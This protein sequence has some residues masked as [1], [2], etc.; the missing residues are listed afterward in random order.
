[1][2]EPKNAFDVFNQ[3]DDE[4]FHAM[5]FLFLANQ[6]K[7]FLK[8]EPFDFVINQV[9]YDGFKQDLFLNNNDDHYQIIVGNAARGVATT[10]SFV[11]RAEYVWSKQHS[12]ASL[13]YI[14]KSRLFYVMNLNCDEPDPATTKFLLDQLPL[15]IGVKQRQFLEIPQGETMQVFHASNH[16]DKIIC[17]SSSKRLA[18]RKSK[19]HQDQWRLAV[20]EA[21]LFGDQAKFSCVSESKQVFRYQQ[22]GRVIATK[23][24]R[25]YK[26]FIHTDEM[27]DIKNARYSAS[28]VEAQIE[29]ERRILQ[30]VPYLKSSN[31]FFF[32]DDKSD[33]IYAHFEKKLPGKTLYYWVKTRFYLPDEADESRMREI[34]DDEARAIHKIENDNNLL[35]QSSMIS[36]CNLL[37]LTIAQRIQLALALVEALMRVHAAGIIHLDLKPENVVTVFNGFFKAWFVDFNIS[38]LSEEV[39]PNNSIV[40]SLLYMSPEAIKR[41]LPGFYSD[42]FSLGIMLAECFGATFAHLDTE[43]DVFEALAKPYCFENLF[44]DVDELTPSLEVCITDILYGMVEFNPEK[45]LSLSE[46]RAAF[47]K[48][49]ALAQGGFVESPPGLVAPLSVFSSEQSQPESSVVSTKGM[50]HV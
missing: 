28:R 44:L 50:N 26:R 46:V 16:L 23:K 48:T 3:S 33:R 12:V 4:H 11:V 7:R 32:I 17:V 36:S 41:T 19:K 43:Q 20:I 42:V 2:F 5:L 39:T 35:L 24:P 38:R 27:R 10:N 34:T 30:K 13:D 6:K 9:S 31:I 8:D 14:R 45:R 49:L 1:M 22:D 25:V 21:G 47:K 40:G 37:G 29:L 18:L 15:V